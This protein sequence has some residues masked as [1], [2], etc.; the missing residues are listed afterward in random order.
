MAG[1]WQLSKFYITCERGTHVRGLPQASM[2]A[3]MET[4]VSLYN[5]DYRKITI[6]DL[7]RDRAWHY[8]QGDELL[9]FHRYEED[10]PRWKSL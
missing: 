9:P 2:A 5:L 8:R 10:D 4:A 1:S 6:M 3:A 7:Q